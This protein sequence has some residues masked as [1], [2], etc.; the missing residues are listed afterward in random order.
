MKILFKY[1][2]RDKLAHQFFGQATTEDLNA[3]INFDDTSIPEKI[4]PV[5]NVEC[6]CYTACYIAQNKTKKEYDIDEL[7]SR[8]PHNQFGADPRD[9]LSEVVKNG[10]KVKGTNTYEKPFSSYWRADTGLHDA[11]DNARSAQLIV[12]SPISICSYWYENW[13]NLPPNSVMPVGVKPLS[14]HMYADKGWVIKDVVNVNGQP[15]F[16]IEWWGGYTLLMPRETFNATLKPL[17]MTSWVLSDAT[18]DA[19]R[20]KTYLEMIKDACIN[21]IILLKQLLILRQSP[22]P[23]ISE[24]P[25]IDPF[26]DYQDVKDRIIQPETLKWSNPVDVR[27]SIRVICD[28]QGLSVSDKN[29]ICA[30]IQAESGFDVHAIHK[31]NNG[32]TDYGLV[33]MNDKYWIGNG[34]YFKDINE[35]YADPKKSVLFI[36][37]SF[38]QGRLDRWYAYTN[39]SYKKYLTS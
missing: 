19:K 25:V 10:L 31:N 26:K 15:M 12:Q 30:V 39:G 21:V 14:G 28:E 11:F 8:I 6:T 34:K 4:Q 17:G 3:P 35:V 29:L 2:S 1:D 7:F 16:V 33:Q 18:I 38:K 32:S 23:I 5:G 24:T 36:I 37:D 9:V 13:L 20:Q 22:K 27:H